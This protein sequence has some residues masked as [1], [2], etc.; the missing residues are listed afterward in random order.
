MQSERDVVS[1]SPSPAESSGSPRASKRVWWWLRFATLA[2][3][4]VLLGLVVYNRPGA[5]RGGNVTLRLA[6]PEEWCLG[7]DF[8]FYV[9]QLT[10]AR[11]AGGR[12]WEVAAD[13]LMGQPYQT[14]LA[15][16]PALFEGVD[17]MLLSAVTGRFVDPV[18]NFHLIVMI[19]LAFNGWVAGGLVLRLTRSFYWAVLAQV[20]ITMHYEPLGRAQG[21]LHLF[22]YGWIVLA[23]WAFSRFLDSPSL[24]RG[25]LLGLAVALVLQSSFYFGFFL[26]VALGLWWIGCLAAGRLDRTHWIASGAAAVTFGAVGAA[27]T[28]PVW[29]ISKRLL[30]TDSFFERSPYDVWVFGA[31]LWQ[32]VMPKQ[33]ILNGLGDELRSHGVF[34]W[35][36][37]SIFPGCA[38]LL[39]IAIYVVARLRGRQLCTTDPRLLDRIMGICALLVVLSLRGGPAVFLYQ[40]VGSFRCYARAGAMAW[41]L[42]CIAGPVILCNA[43]RRIRPRFLGA[44]LALGI[45]ATIGF[46][47]YLLTTGFYWILTRDEPPAW[48]RWLAEQPPDVRL[49]AFEPFEPIN[50]L[51]SWGIVNSYPRTRHNHA[52]LNGCDYRLLDA[53]LRL[54]GASYQKMNPDGL[55]FIASLGYATLAFHRAYLDAHPWI[56]DLDW[57]DPRDAF[58]DWLIYR[59]NARLPQF[60]VRSLERL[61]AEQPL[62][63]AAAEVPPRAWI[64][65][66]LDVEETVV[67]ERSPRVEIAWADA[68]GRLVGKPYPALYQHVFGPD[69]PAYTI[70]TPTNAGEYRLVILDSHR[71]ELASKR[72]VVVPELR[73]GRAAPGHGLPE[74]T[75]DTAEVRKE[76]FHSN[77][78]RVTLENRSPYYLQAHRMRDLAQGAAC[79]HPG[80]ATP[81]EGSIVVALRYMEGEATSEQVNVVLPRDLPARG[82]LEMDVPIEWQRGARTPDRVRIAPYVAALGPRAAEPGQLRLSIADESWQGAAEPA[83]LK[84]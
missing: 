26:M 5:G 18:L 46:E 50:P 60:P 53:D 29:T 81:S 66:G 10:R 80:L 36:G 54:L 82:R 62:S 73:A 67:V 61:I 30:F 14:E 83:A 51:Y 72:Y 11:E 43:A 20:L 35:E 57:L 7:P 59:V 69:L 63:G 47:A 68:R 65:G 16:T 45:T 49:A 21:H 76:A 41:A 3:V 48:S 9:Y 34:P 77:H 78:I 23:V 39:A 37:S 42:A 52:T 32:Y 19:I 75:V 27:L 8:E 70:R 84:R 25:T 4:P 1:P 6:R 17:L 2:V 24:R 71:R 31:E 12:W 64:T 38:L 33:W 55:R 28:F 44:V 58:G 15:K 40:L 22:K 13:P 79:S 56:R 74:F